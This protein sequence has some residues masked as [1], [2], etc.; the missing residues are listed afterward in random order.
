MYNPYNRGV[1]ESGN[2]VFIETVVGGDAAADF[3]IGNNGADTFSSQAPV[4]ATSLP[5]TPHSTILSLITPHCGVTTTYIHLNCTLAVLCISKI[6]RYT[7]HL[8]TSSVMTRR[9]GIMPSPGPWCILH[10]LR[11]TKSPT[12]STTWSHDVKAVK[13]PYGRGRFSIT[14]QREAFKPFSDANWGNNPKNG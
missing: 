6:P 1:R 4:P 8:P 14:Y 13:S 3:L 9:R 2:G 5:A 7:I 10:R 11:A 12:L